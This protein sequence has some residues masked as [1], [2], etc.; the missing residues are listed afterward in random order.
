MNLTVPLEP[1]NFDNI[2][3]FHITVRDAEPV[4]ELE[5]VPQP[6]PGG[7]LKSGVCAG[8]IQISRESNY[9]KPEQKLEPDCFFPER[10]S[11]PGPKPEPS[12]FLLPS[13]IST[14]V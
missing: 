12:I 11:E 7:F 10:E 2:M 8:A 13:L 1:R 3:L 5:P 6:E 14:C 9:L 4:P